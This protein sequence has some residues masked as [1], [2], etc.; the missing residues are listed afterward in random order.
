MVSIGQI[1]TCIVIAALQSIASAG[2]VSLENEAIDINTGLAAYYP[3]DGN[4]NDASGKG[5]HGTVNGPVLTADRLGVSGKAYQFDGSDDYIRTTDSSSLNLTGDLSISAWIR[6]TRRGDNAILF[7]NMLEVSP[8]SGYQLRFIPSGGIRFMSGSQSVFGNRVVPLNTWTR[9]TA[10]LSGTTARVYINNVL[11]LA[12]TVGVPTT[13]S[14]DQ[15]IGSSYS[16]FYF[17]QG[18][19]DDLRVYN[20]ALSFSEVQQLA[21]LPEPSS[22][23]L[24]LG[25]AAALFLRRR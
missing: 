1:S 23:V 4:A 14:V 13:S 22:I 21:L 5:N 20:R 11:D 24:S 18:G 3:F 15:T 7:S 17:Y 25:G 8:H 6:P 9:V 12:G 16:P 19:M 2:E 10:T